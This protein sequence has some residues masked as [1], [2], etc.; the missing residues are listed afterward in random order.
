MELP[1]WRRLRAAVMVWID[2]RRQRDV[3][4]ERVIELE[5][6]VESLK[7]R[8]AGLESDVAAVSRWRGYIG[9]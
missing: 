8:I 3:L 4:A 7:D 5:N 2:V 9:S 6:H 1:M